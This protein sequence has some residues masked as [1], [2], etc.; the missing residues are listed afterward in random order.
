MISKALQFTNEI[1]DQYLK[2]RFA[3]D[4]SKVVLNNLIESNGSIP[5]INNNKVVMSLINIEKET[6]KPFYIRHQKL[7]DGN[8]ADMSP[9]ERYNL[10]V[11]ISSSFA[12][13]SECLKFLDAVILFFQVNICVDSGSFSMPA[14][15]DKLEFE[16]EKI[17]YHQ[18][19]GL[20]TSMGAKYM[21]SVIYKIRLVKFQ[22]NEIEGVT[23]YVGNS[24]NL[25]SA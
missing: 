8:Y 4:E 17:N 19:Q 21:P 12:N 18:M 1:L 24:G 15:L 6:S 25:V 5:E 2:N 22:G 9:S 11:L 13:Y 7:Q 20:W 10:D 23:P 16:I 3:L 14:G